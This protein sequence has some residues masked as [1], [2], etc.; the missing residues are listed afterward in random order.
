[1]FSLVHVRVF[2]HPGSCLTFTVFPEL[3]V[4]GAGSTC[5]VT[6]PIRLSG[7]RY[8]CKGTPHPHQSEC[9]FTACWAFAPGLPSAPRSLRVPGLPALAWWLR[10]CCVA[11]CPIPPH[12]SSSGCAVCCVLPR[13]TRKP[14]SRPLLAVA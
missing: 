9:L 10:A 14:C 7:R 6:G 13:C 4:N 1:M 2:S 3:T 8:L 5:S 11:V 12:R